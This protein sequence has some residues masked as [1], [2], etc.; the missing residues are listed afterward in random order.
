M[1][2]VLVVVGLLVGGAVFFQKVVRWRW[3]RDPAEDR[4]LAARALEELLHPDGYFGDVGEFTSIPVGNDEGLRQIQEDL[5]RLL[6]DDANFIEPP[7]IGNEYPALSG[8]GRGRVIELG[9]W[10]ER[11]LPGYTCNPDAPTARTA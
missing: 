7:R 10:L 8:S 11:Q 5:I 4:W 9:R 6:E 1:K 2:I 3:F